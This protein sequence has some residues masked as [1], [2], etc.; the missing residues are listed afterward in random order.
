M[1]HL[2]ARVPRA[3]DLS[4]DGSFAAQSPHGFLKQEGAQGG[5]VCLPTLSHGSERQ[6]VESFGAGVSFS[7]RILQTCCLLGF[8]FLLVPLY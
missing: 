2:Q 3:W 4:P 1:A 5:P 7:K 6:K 8:C